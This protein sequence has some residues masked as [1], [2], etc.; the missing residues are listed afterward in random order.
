MGKPTE[1]GAVALAELAVVL[2]ALDGDA[3]VNVLHLLEP[4]L[5]LR[6]LNLFLEEFVPL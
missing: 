1:D 2:L 4:D 3:L 6:G 5:L